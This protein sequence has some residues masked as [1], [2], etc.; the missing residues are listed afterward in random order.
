MG[1]GHVWSLF[2]VYKRSRLKDRSENEENH[3]K[4]HVFQA[5]TP[6]LVRTPGED[7]RDDGVEDVVKGVVPRRRAATLRSSNGFMGRNIDGCGFSIATFDD[8][9][10]YPLV[11]TNIAMV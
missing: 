9:M 6:L 1:F 11:M 4:L 7:C 2:L 3:G 5:S 10:V 8:Q